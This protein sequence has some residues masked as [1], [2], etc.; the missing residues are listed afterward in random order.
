IAGS[1][2]QSLIANVQIGYRLFLR[3]D[4]S[5]VGRIVNVES[6]RAF[7]DGTT[8]DAIIIRAPDGSV[9]PI[10]R[11]TAQQIYVTRP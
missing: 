9:F 7:E 3:T 5:Y 6:D 4:H 1:E 8:R 2:D 11:K 10:P